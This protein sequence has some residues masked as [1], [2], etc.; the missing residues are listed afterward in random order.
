MQLSDYYQYLQVKMNDPKKSIFEEGQTLLFNKPVF[1]YDR[2]VCNLISFK[3]E[4]H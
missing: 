1:I 4:T 2:P 3:Q